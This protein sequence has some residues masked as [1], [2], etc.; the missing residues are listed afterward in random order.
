MKTFYEWLAQFRLIETY[1]GLDPKQYDQLF[2]AELEKVIK[3]VRD[4]A[5]REA[6]EGMRGFRWL[7]YIAASVRNAGFRDQREVQEKAHDVAVKL[8]AVLQ[9]RLDGGET[10]SLVGCDALGSPGKWKIKQVVQEIKALARE[11][12]TAI[13]DSELLRRIEK[14]MEAEEETLAKRR[15]STAAARATVG[16]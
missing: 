10:K 1:Y 2:D 7:S 9:V 12:A 15:T 11:Y 16:A 13:G 14:A 5:H 6:L 3:Q 4:P 8:L